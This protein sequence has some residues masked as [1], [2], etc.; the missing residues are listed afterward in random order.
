MQ[1][2][3]H[4][5]FLLLEQGRIAQDLEWLFLTINFSTEESSLNG[6]QLIEPMM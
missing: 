2:L 5:I 4:Y 3:C 1:R 6:V